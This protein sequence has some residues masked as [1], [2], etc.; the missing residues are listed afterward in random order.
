MRLYLS[1]IMLHKARRC[2]ELGIQTA[3]WMQWKPGKGK[4]TDRAAEADE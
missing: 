1:V 3:T 4:Y 2:G